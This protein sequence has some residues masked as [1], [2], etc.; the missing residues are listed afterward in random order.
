MTGNETVIKVLDLHQTA[1]NFFLSNG[2][3]ERILHFKDEVY[4]LLFTSV[5]EYLQ[6]YKFLI[7]TLTSAAG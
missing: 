3:I 7:K 1:Y 5:I 6:H 4:R 2:E